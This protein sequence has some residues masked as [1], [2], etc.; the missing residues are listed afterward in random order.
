[1]TPSPMIPKTHY[2]RHG[3]TQGFRVSA[4]IVGPAL[5]FRAKVFQQFRRPDQAAGVGGE[6]SRAAALHA[7]QPQALLEIMPPAHRLD[8]EQP[9]RDRG[10]HVE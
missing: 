8:P 2:P 9:D 5:L 3:F 1:M 6:D 10:R 4:L 7:W